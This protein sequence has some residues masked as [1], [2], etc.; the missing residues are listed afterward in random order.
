MTARFSK[1][2]VVVAL[3][4]TTG[5]HWAVLQSVAWTTMLANNL[6]TQSLAEA[7]AHTFE[8]QASLLSLQNHCRRQKIREENRVRPANPKNRIPAVTRTPGSGRAFALSTVA[9]DK[10]FR[11][12][13]RGSAADTATPR[14][15]RLIQSR[16]LPAPCGCGHECFPFNLRAP[17]RVLAISKF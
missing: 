2:L 10:Q 11:R 3:V 9:V 7:V 15:L 16:L 5:L 1:F 8:R 12:T 14:T 13:S 4:A 6:R 17:W